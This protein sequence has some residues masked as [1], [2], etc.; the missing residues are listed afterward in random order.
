MKKKWF[1]ESK[2]YWL[3]QIGFW[4]GYNA[5]LWAAVIDGISF[6]S[7]ASLVVSISICCIVGTHFYHK[8]LIIN[9]IDIF[10]WQRAIPYMSICMGVTATLIELISISIPVHSTS[11][12]PPF[13]YNNSL[14]FIFGVF[15]SVFFS[16]YRGFWAIMS[17][18]TISH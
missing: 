8:S 15:F 16:S 1:L 6:G 9:G 18:S 13:V 14:Y 3:T 17:F 10:N 12:E 5:L 2:T 11:K 4:V 7:W